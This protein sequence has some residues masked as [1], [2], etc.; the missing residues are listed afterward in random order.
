MAI[1]ACDLAIY[2]VWWQTKCSFRANIF[3]RYP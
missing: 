2:R 1:K 3:Q